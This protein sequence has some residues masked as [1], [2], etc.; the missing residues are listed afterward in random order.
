MAF[1]WRA[2]TLLVTWAFGF[3]N[4]SNAAPEAEA[5]FRPH[6]Q[7]ATAKKKGCAFRERV[8]EYS[9]HFTHLPGAMNEED[10]LCNCDGIGKH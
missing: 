1:C 2:R 7:C 10:S 9:F 6:D 8:L 5:W 4:P 3:Y